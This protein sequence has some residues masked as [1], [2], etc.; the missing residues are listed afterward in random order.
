M[1][2]PRPTT[3]AIRVALTGAAGGFG[4]TVLLALRDHASQRAA[5][6]CDL[7]L[8]SA[9]RQL[10]ELGYAR[11][12]VVECATAD[13]VTAA[14]DAGRI[15][16]VAS[17]DLL[18]PEAYDVLV[19]ATGAVRVSVR[20]ALDAI[21]AARPVVLASKE[22]ESLFG[23]LLAERAADRGVV[24]TTGAGDQPANL[25]ALLGWAERLGLRVVAAGKSSEYDLVF[26][27]AAGTA[28]V[29][30]HTIDAPALGAHWDLGDDLAATLAARRE[31]VRDLKL[32]AA[33]D[34][35]EIAVV[36]NLTGL[37]VD[38]PEMHY[39]IVRY[40][41]LADV[42]RPRSAG[43]IL[44]GEAVLDVFT[45]LRE[46]GEAS[47]AGGEFIVVRCPD[48]EVARV[49]AQK[50]HVVSASGDHLCIGLPFHLMGLEIPGTIADAVAGIP[51]AAPS[52]RR[53]TMVATVARPLTAGF[54]FRV[55]GHHHEID[56]TTPAL[57]PA[58]EA[59]D[60]AV[61]YY[62]LDGAQL[63]RDVP[64]GTRIGFDDVAGIDATL[65]ELAALERTPRPVRTH[66]GVS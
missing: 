12:Q 23:R 22:T 63:R 6:L 64:A 37:A 10:D 4:R 24:S 13:A 30:D 62:L 52:A 39:P 41:E 29:L 27:R 59:G 16:L 38:T 53:T 58:A 28:S 46:P 14:V 65:L 2:S 7:D 56:G 61:P 19:E 57:V 26:D 45:L 35:C 44:T 34:Y 60:T 36:A 11:D 40:R 25:V 3:S 21:D 15:A 66:E 31:A 55:A 42:L 54:E 32:G 1:N 8:A 33:A 47:F 18:V 43:G 51:V 5:V 50:G 49:L 48:P 9:A 20:A 17:T